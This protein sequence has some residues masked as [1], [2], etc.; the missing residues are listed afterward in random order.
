M[1]DHVK[2]KRT[3]VYSFIQGL[4]LGGLAKEGFWA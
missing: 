1:I 3:D 4:L 2:R